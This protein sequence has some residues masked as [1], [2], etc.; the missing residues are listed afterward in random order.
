MNRSELDLPIVKLMM[1]QD[2]YESYINSIDKK[3]LSEEA[4][5]LLQDFEI[6]YNKYNKDIELVDFFDWFSNVR[7]KGFSDTKKELF[8]LVLQNASSAEVSEPKHLLA[9]LKYEQMLEEFMKNSDI[10]ADRVKSIL[11][12]YANE[13]DKLEEPENITDYT[14]FDLSNVFNTVDRSTGLRWRLSGLQKCIGG[15]IRGDLVVIAAYTDTGKTA[16]VASEATHMATQMQDKKVLWFNNEGSNE[17][18]QIRLLCSALNRTQT[19]INENKERAMS[20]YKRVMNGDENRILVYPAHGKS[21]QYITDRCKSQDCGLLVIDQLDNIDGFGKKE[22]EVIKSRYLYQWARE[23]AT[24]HAPLLAV[25]QASG[26][27]SYINRQT[28]EEE[29]QLYLGM[30]QLDW[31]KV[32]KQS[33]AE[34]IITIGRSTTIPSQRG[35]SVPKN[36]SNVETY[37]RNPKFLCNFNGATSRYED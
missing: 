19:Q 13:L 21:T 15:L 31:S 26:N 2:S 36:K 10:S 32:A 16:F 27:T 9:R 23:L 35:I 28:N 3:S 33:A 14:T 4:T 17:R 29:Y 18:V 1:N 8:K 11:D 20:W 24:E 5:I 22:N 6:Y 37:D 7:H 12:K 30:H 25:T 34:M